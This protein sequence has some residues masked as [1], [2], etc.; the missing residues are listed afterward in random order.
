MGLASQVKQL[1]VKL[2][3]ANGES[4]D[5]GPGD[6]DRA[7]VVVSGT[8]VATVRIDVSV[9]GTNFAPALLP[10]GTTALP[11]FTAPGSKMIGGDAVKVRVATT[12]YTSGTPAVSIMRRPALKRADHAVA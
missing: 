1:D 10:D 8:F 11:T 7:L 4:Q 9:D 3:V 6:L 5:V 12:V 2:A